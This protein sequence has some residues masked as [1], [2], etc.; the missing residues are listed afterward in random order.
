[1]VI[2]SVIKNFYHRFIIPPLYNTLTLNFKAR[3][4]RKEYVVFW[5]SVGVLSVCFIFFVI[6]GISLTRWCF[7][8]LFDIAYPKW[9][10]NHLLQLFAFAC[11]V[12]IVVFILPFFVST[13]N[14]LKDANINIW[15]LFPLF[16]LIWLW[17]SNLFQFS[18]NSDFTPL[19]YQILGYLLDFYFIFIIFLA[20]FLPT[21]KNLK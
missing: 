6:E 18:Y 19:I 8:T 4:T 2:F 21:A 11:G 9:D 10:L 13:A 17:I 16:L 3:L 1:M 14:R 12:I 5:L 7:R 15:I 20:I